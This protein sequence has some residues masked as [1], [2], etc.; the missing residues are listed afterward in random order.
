M[1][2]TR[3]FELQSVGLGQ[4][5]HPFELPVARPQHP[6][7]DLQFSLSDDVQQPVVRQ[8]RTEKV[9]PSNPVGGSLTELPM[10]QCRS[11]VAKSQAS[12]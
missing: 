10:R 3:V 6:Q 1:T 11:P 5:Q 2:P 8:R 12:R 7:R 4:R 9:Q